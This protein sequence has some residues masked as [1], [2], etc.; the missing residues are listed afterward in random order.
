MAYFGDKD[1]RDGRRFNDQNGRGGQRNRR[2]G[3]PRRD[4]SDFGSRG[5]GY[6]SGGERGGFQ[7]RDREN[8][9][10]GDRKDYGRE[11]RGGSRRN[12][13]EYGRGDQRSGYRREG[14]DRFERSERSN[15][16]SEQGKGFRG[17]DRSGYQRR[18]RDGFQRE[19]RGG[20]GREERGGFRRV[21]RGD[22]QRQ[23]G[24]SWE[25]GGRK[26]YRH[27]DRED[28]RRSD[29]NG[30]RRDARA[31][32]G[33]EERESWRRTA[34]ED[35]RPVSDS[36][37]LGQEATADE[38]QS[39]IDNQF[40]DYIYTVDG[41]PIP[42]GVE[43]TELDE[44][45]YNALATLGE[46]N[47]SRVGKL[48]VMA[49]QLIDLDPEQA[50]VYA[51]AAV[52]RAGRVDVVREAAALTAYS[53]GRYAEALREVR[54][55]RRMR[56]DESLRAVEADCERGLG[57]PDKALEIVEKTQM[58]VL[59]L[60]EQVELVIVAAGARADMEE[61]DTALVLLSD[62]LHKL[63]DHANEELRRRLML[64]QA[65][66]LRQCGRHQEA[67]EVEAQAP[68]EVEDNDIVD[69]QLFADADI[70]N[71]RSDLKGSGK[72]L[73]ESY[74]TLL[75]D[76][77]G[78]CYMGKQPVDH[79]GEGISAA[80]DAGMKHV[81]VTN[82]SSRTP[83]AI[84]SQLNELGIPATAANIMTSAMDVI[85]VMSEDVPSGASVYVIGG[86]GLRQALCE[87]GYRVVESA[88]ERPDAVVQGF[89][90]S[91]DWKMLSEGAIAISAGAKYYATNMDASLPVERGFALGNGALVRAVR[92]CTNTKPT[93]AGKP[94][95]GIFARAIA[96][97]E[98]ERAI[99][100]GDRLETDIACAIN[101]QVPAMHVLTGVHDAKA[102]ILA[103]RGLRP[104]FVHTDM[105]GLLQPH[106]RPNH[107]K[108]GTWTCG[109][110]QV[111]K[112]IQGHLSLDGVV[113]TEATTVTL[114]SYRALIAAAWE[115]AENNPK[116]ICPILTV[117]DNEDP[118]GIVV[119]PAPTEDTADGPAD[120]LVEGEAD[121]GDEQATG[122]AA[123][124]EETA[125]EQPAQ[126]SVT[127]QTTGEN[128]P[129]ATTNDEEPAGV[130][131]HGNHAGSEDEPDLDPELE[132][133]LANVDIDDIDPFL[134]GEEDLQQLLEETRH[135]EDN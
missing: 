28:R 116:V 4:R 135:L 104:Q 132:A 8:F 85:S 35:E 106:P 123:A 10:R 9:E 17:N 110:S 53:S 100:V 103:E 43:A 65:D 111:A 46:H 1:G 95:P 92:Y 11:D 34:R 56:N 90:A 91:V 89:D 121:A 33:W 25:R 40:E 72:P 98:G 134:P 51:Q 68:A 120:L 49:G 115:W 18:E 117:V 2:D 99:A 6:S 47:Q 75:L 19:D 84:A 63:A 83:Q 5:A 101:A 48:L 42:A 74:D 113:L 54:A 60:S 129:A 12:E 105:R 80:V 24:N 119:A 81:F 125:S 36:N 78:V 44:A 126:V 38:L 15:F 59:P 86:D 82:N 37:A 88:D 58:S 41:L 23:E 96:L 76:L 107:H 7:R 32:R 64:A 93:A 22:Y 61:Y 13:R 62:A 108:D 128:P 52:K 39:S 73:A 114:D 45:T 29:S 102:V 133:K 122:A 16:R 77:D 14:R 21:G 20:F 3:Q 50:Y 118:A 131:A 79:A 70:D 87:A 124:A 69:V 66:V 27:G 127:T 55:V 94:L 31:G 97:A 30:Y 26:N 109:V 130:G 71:L 67:D 57:K 112:V